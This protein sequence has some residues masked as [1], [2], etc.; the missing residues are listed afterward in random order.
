M[1]LTLYDLPALVITS[2]FQVWVSFGKQF[3]FSIP[4]DIAPENMID[5]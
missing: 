4:G 3:S 5:A 2:A 1:R